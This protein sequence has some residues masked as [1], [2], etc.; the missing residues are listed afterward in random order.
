MVLSLGFCD[1]LNVKW[2]IGMTC[3]KVCGDPGGGAN[4][5]IERDTG[6]RFDVLDGIGDRKSVLPVP[7]GQHKRVDVAS[8]GE[9]LADTRRRAASRRN[10][11]DNF[12]RDIAGFEGIGFLGA[13]PEHTGV[14]AFQTHHPLPTFGGGD[15]RLSDLFLGPTVTPWG[16]AH[17]NALGVAAGQFQNF[18]IKQAVIINHICFL[19]ALHTAQGDQIFCSGA[20]THKADAAA[21]CGPEFTCLDGCFYQLGRFAFGAAGEQLTRCVI[22]DPAPQ[23]PP[24]AGGKT[25]RSRAAH[26]TRKGRKIAQGEVQVP[27]PVWS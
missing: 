6:A 10:T 2:N 19:Q 5:H 7:C 1:D 23:I 27:L 21:F 8:F 18:G 9:A 4:S 17:I 11:G 13:A 24:R 12:K 25:G 3:F 16:F 20:C 22:E 14:T 15:K 26:T